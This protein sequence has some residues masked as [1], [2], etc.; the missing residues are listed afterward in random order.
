MLSKNNTID[1]MHDF[2]LPCKIIRNIGETKEEKTIFSLEIAQ[3]ANTQ[4][5][6]TQDDLKANS[7]EQLS[8]A[9]EMRAVGVFYQTKR[10]EEISSKEYS[11]SYRKTKLEQVG[12]LCMAAIFQMPCVSRNKKAL[13][14][15]DIYYKY[16][17]IE[18]QP[19]VAAICKELLYI[20][21]YFDKIFKPKFKRDN[22]NIEDAETRIPFASKARTICIAFTALA[23]RWYYHKNITD[24]DLK[25]IFEASK[26]QSNSATDNMYKV[27]RDIGEMKFLFP[28]KL[29]ENMELYDAALD[30]LFIAIIE[31]GIWVYSFVR[32]N[33]PKLTEN[34]FLQ[35]D[36]NYYYILKRCW[37]KS[38]KPKINEVFADV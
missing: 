10:G 13:I 25:T 6:I 7:P 11:D 14:Y 24:Q 9:R 22:E 20:N 21:Y 4:K 36:K 16:I 19:K 37:E 12:K 17:F 5:P 35:N 8:F 18:K 27:L 28:K 3:A 1:I 2:Y 29:S 34:A 38:L 26:S 32:D 30:K 33:A 15:K 31:E 23:A